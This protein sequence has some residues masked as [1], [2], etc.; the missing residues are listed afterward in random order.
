M[1]SSTAG[2]SDPGLRATMIER[3]RAIV[4]ALR[5]RAYQAKQDRSMPD[6]THCEFV[7]AGFY[8]LFQPTRFGGYEMDLAMMVDMCAELGRGCGS[9]AWLF[10]NI[11]SV[12]WMVGMHHPETQSLT[13]H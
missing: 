1:A 5:E 2:R 13:L 11:S 4:P 9:S 12:S 8:R 10:S 6:A 3:A 7:E